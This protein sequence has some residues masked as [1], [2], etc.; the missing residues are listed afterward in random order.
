MSIK[1]WIDAMVQSERL[2]PL[3][4]VLESDP[5]SREMYLSPEVFALIEG[6]WS[7]TDAE[8]RC[9]ELRSD[10]DA[11]VAGQTRTICVKP[12]QARNEQLAILHPVDDGVWDIRSQKPSPGI[13]V[14]GM[15][16]QRDVFLALIP[17][18][19]SI[20]VDYIDRGPLGEKCDPAWAEI[21]SETKDLWRRTMSPYSPI[22]GDNPDDYFSEGYHRS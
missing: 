9:N 11:F 21:I 3:V 5:V 13:R 18:T 4:P 16:A 17:A 10:L 19:R 12:F 7:S 2:R 20:K 6:P 1:D 22:T 8:K 15:F 14:L